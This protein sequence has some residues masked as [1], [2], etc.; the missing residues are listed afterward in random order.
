MNP[1]SG[2]KIMA[3]FPHLHFLMDPRMEWRFFLRGLP[4]WDWN[5]VPNNEKVDDTGLPS[6]SDK[7]LK[8][9]VLTRDS[10]SLHIL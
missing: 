10:Y 7:I 1:V 9:K 3:S 6:C 8:Q 5:L 4:A 2:T